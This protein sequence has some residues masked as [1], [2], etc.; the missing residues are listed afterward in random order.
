MP[1]IT[2]T[3]VDFFKKAVGRIGANI[4]EWDK[5]K[6]NY[7]IAKFFYMHSLGLSEKESEKIVSNMHSFMDYQLS[8]MRLSEESIDYTDLF[9]FVPTMT[10]LFYKKEITAMNLVNSWINS[11]GLSIFTEIEYFPALLTHLLVLIFG[12]EFVNQRYDLRSKK[13]AIYQRLTVVLK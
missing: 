10:K 13:D 7:A 6:V 2:D 11:F 4:D 8:D 5:D 12:V 1:L 3:Y 9:T